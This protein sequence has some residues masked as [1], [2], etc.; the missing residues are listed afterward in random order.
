MTYCGEMKYIHF[1]KNV[2]YDNK[3]YVDGK[4]SWFGSGG[5]SEKN[6]SVVLQ[7]LITL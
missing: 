5:E 1:V 4:T 7:F 2:S 3:S 6:V